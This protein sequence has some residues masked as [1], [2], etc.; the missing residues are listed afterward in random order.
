MSGDSQFAHLPILQ[1]SNQ[2]REQWWSW[3]R[4]ERGKCVRYFEFKLLFSL[5]ISLPLCNNY[6]HNCD[7]FGIVLSGKSV[8]SVENW[9]QQPLCKQVKL[10]HKQKSRFRRENGFWNCRQILKIFGKLFN[11]MF[12]LW[13][14]KTCT[15]LLLFASHFSLSFLP[16]EFKRRDDWIF[17]KD[18]YSPSN[19]AAIIW[20]TFFGS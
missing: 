18:L 11:K 3:L 7:L 13:Y 14:I 8:K 6:N 10:L 19:P 16:S 12:K 4:W 15:K 9:R 20:N 5:C 1:S 2:R 17:C